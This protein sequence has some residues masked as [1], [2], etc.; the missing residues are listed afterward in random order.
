[1]PN[2]I[3]GG[4]LGRMASEMQNDRYRDVRRVKG[5]G[6]PILIL[7]LREARGFVVGVG[8]CAV[9]VARKLC[10]FV[11]ANLIVVEILGDGM[12]VVEMWVSVYSVSCY[13]HVFK[14]NGITN[15]GLHL[16]VCANITFRGFLSRNANDLLS[17]I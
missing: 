10:L 12:L 4:N 11:D 6:G 13:P 9:G 16:H 1:V 15:R 5:S 7:L 14:G 17:K 8:E 3:L 2:L